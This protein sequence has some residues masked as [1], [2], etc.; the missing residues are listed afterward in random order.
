[1]RRAAPL[2]GYEA[3][4]AELCPGRPVRFF[5]VEGLSTP[6]T[7]GALRPVV[8]LPQGEIHPAA[9]HHE[10][11][12]IRRWDV[13]W[14]GLILLACALH[15]FNPLVWLLSR[16][17]EG[18]MEAACDALVVAGQDATQRRVYGELL[19]HTA[20]GQRFPLTTRFS[21]EKARMKTRLRDLYHPGKGSRVL[22]LAVAIVC[23]LAGGL[24]ACRSTGQTT[25]N[26]DDGAQSQNVIDEKEPGAVA[27]GIYCAPMPESVTVDGQTNWEQWQFTLSTYDPETGERG[28]Q[29]STQILPLA[30]EL[31]L[32]ALGAEQPTNA[33]TVG[34]QEWNRQVVGFL[35]WPL[36][37]SSFSPDATDLLEV[38]VQDGAVTA[39]KWFQVPKTAS[40]DGD[41]KG[42]DPAPA[43]ETYADSEAP[44]PVSPVNTDSPTPSVDDPVK[45]DIREDTVSLTEKEDAV[46]SE[47]E[48][49]SSVLRLDGI[50]YIV[51]NGST[52]EQVHLATPSD[53]DKMKSLLNDISILSRDDE[54][55][56]GYLYAIRAEDENGNLSDAICVYKDRVQ[57]GSKVGYSVKNDEQLRDYL[58]NL[59]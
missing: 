13:A 32:W 54:L 22:V 3:L 34:T 28:T 24:T 10:L 23:L 49:L 45:E 38:R 57:I 2:T 9:V 42:E 37:R 39:L 16:R 26:G 5:R 50:S 20:A 1:M 27:D 21:G 7:F 43:V 35:S 47:L 12:H 58:K 30:Q 59:F 19:L 56:V 41:T 55:S 36:V 6:M 48:T 25:D 44:A 29:T 11:I 14:K 33:G 4:A 17:A 52:G 15:W 51:T 46:V 40:P 31:T 8:A 53:V 18:D